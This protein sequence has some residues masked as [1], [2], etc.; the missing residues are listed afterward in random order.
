MKKSKISISDIIIIILYILIGLSGYLSPFVNINNI[1][2]MASILLFIIGI[3]VC[4]KFGVGAFTFL[5]I[6]S[7]PGFG[8]LL[9]YLVRF[10]LPDGKTISIY[11][12]GLSSLFT[13]SNLEIYTSTII[14]IL[15][16]TI[17]YTLL[18]NLS[19]KLKVNKIHSIIILSM[20]LIIMILITLLPIVFPT[21]FGL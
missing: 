21:V 11:E 15:G 16:I 5:I 20:Y 4:L 14:I 1:G 19:Y 8:L 9:N 6:T 17:I 3:F 12:K 13:T 10:K 7:G 2:Y 18:H